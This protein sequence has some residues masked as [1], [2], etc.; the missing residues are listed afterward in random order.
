MATD[1]ATRFGHGAGTM[2]VALGALGFA[3]TGTDDPLAGNGPSLLV[4]EV[5]P[6]LNLLH[7]AVGTVV[8]GGAAASPRAAHTT[9]MLAAAALGVLGLLG[10][11]LSRMDANPLALNTWDNLLHLALSTWATVAAVRAGRQLPPLGARRGPDS[12]PDP[13]TVR[14]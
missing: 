2:L 7:A 8:V 13:R 11:A 6:A 4:L 1:A 14:S 5:N 3:V 9:T 10:L 12:T